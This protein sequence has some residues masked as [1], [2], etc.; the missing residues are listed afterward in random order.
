L[1]LQKLKSNEA[2]SSEYHL[3]KKKRKLSPCVHKEKSSSMSAEDDTD[4]NISSDDEF[5]QKS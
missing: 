2:R 3:K 5:V 1:E 4:I